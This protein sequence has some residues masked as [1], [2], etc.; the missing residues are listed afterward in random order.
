MKRRMFRIPFT[1]SATILFLVV[2]FNSSE[3]TS[4]VR[5]PHQVPLPSD[6]KVV[7]EDLA[8]WVAGS[9]H[10]RDLQVMSSEDLD[11]A[12]DPQPRRFGLF[13]QDLGEEARRDYLEDLPYGS[14]LAAAAERHDVDGLLLAAVVDAESRFRPRAV[15]PKGAVGLMQVRPSTGSIYGATDLTDPKVNVDVGC[16]YLRSLLE[17]YDGDMELA[18]AA[19]NA[20]P[21]AVE[22]YNGVPP[23]RET[24]AYVEKVLSRYE[25]YQRE[26]WKTA[27]GPLGTAG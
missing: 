1:V 12:L 16:R 15:S 11:A 8:S 18:L 25:R 4:A 13:P 24:R 21:A 9:R 3:T 19:Y 5:D 27:K 23:Y 17:T 7:F 22:R 26:M 10:G 14:I 2:S 6:D 20:G